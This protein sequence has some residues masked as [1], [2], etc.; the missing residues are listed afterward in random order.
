LILEAMEAKTSL[1]PGKPYGSH[2]DEH[3]TDNRA[4]NGHACYSALGHGR[5][6]IP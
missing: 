1:V 4:E 2:A 6:R 3:A 5:F